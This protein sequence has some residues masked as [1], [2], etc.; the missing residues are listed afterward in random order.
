M[1]ASGFNLNYFLKKQLKILKRETTPKQIHLR[2]YLKK[3]IN[4]RKV[5]CCLTNTNL[6]YYQ[7]VSRYLGKRIF[8]FWRGEVL[9]L[10][11]INRLGLNLPFLVGSNLNF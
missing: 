11:K 7:I 5:V 2:F 6:K 9:L 10:F 3:N 8:P 4:K 1:T